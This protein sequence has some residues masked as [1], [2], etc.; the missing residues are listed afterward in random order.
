MKVAIIT[1]ASSGIGAAVAAELSRRG[2][3][4]GLIARRADLLEAMV[5]QLGS[6][7]AAF[8]TADVGKE[9][10]LNQAIADLES[11][12]GPCDLMFANAGIGDGRSARNFTAA[13]AKKILNVN[14]EGV[15]HAFAAVLPGMLDR[16]HGSLAAT[17]S[18]AGFRGLPNFGPYSASKAYVTCLLEAM[19]VDLRTAN[20]S[21]TTVHPGFVVSELTEKNAFKMPFLVPTEKAGRIIASG[22]IRGKAEINFP[23]Q[24][25]C[26]MRL[27]Q[28]VPNWLYDRAVSAFSPTSPKKESS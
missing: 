20:I 27:L 5:E 15:I 18:V 19:R 21:V 25:V 23:W 22:L 14:V 26:L 17:S 1:G 13:A 16:G 3:A 6:D 28:W 7:H 2:W 12:L 11:Q 9:A 4:V 24:M 8:S 10:E